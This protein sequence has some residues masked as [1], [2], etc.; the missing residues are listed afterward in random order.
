VRPAS[1]AAECGG[2]G[3]VAQPAALVPR[4]FESAD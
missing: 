3:Y 2:A 1:V 4:V